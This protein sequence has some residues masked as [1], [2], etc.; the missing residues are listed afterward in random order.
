VSGLRVGWLRR[1]R[2]TVGLG[3][4]DDVVVVVGGVGVLGR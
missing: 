2:R 1:T 3:V 4:V